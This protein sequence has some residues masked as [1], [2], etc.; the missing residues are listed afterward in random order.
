MGTDNISIVT[1]S[2]KNSGIFKIPIARFHIAGI[3]PKQTIQ[4]AVFRKVSVQPPP[5]HISFNKTSILA[6]VVASALLVVA[7]SV[8]KP[9][10]EWVYCL[11]AKTR[12]SLC[13]LKKNRGPERSNGPL[14]SG[15]KY[16]LI[17]L[18]I[19]TD[20]T[21]S[22]PTSTFSQ[23]GWTRTLHSLRCSPS[24]QGKPRLSFTWDSM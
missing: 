9:P 7:S 23:S 18:P 24:I 16:G 10:R 11:G 17:S 4:G 2:R 3:S 20:T 5:S 6:T 1:L 8:G 13:L 12:V 22:W 14:F 19:R 21:R 15:R